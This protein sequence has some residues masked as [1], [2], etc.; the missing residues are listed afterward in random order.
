MTPV[1]GHVA[2]VGAGP[3]DPELITVRGLR[4]LE[5]ADVV[6]VDRLAPRELLARLDP[7]VEIVDAGKRRGCHTL[8]Q[9]AIEAL[10]VERAR[11]GLRV[12]R[13]KGGDPF[14]FGRGGEE[15]L[16]CAAAGIP[17]EVVPGVSSAFAGPARAGIP[18]THRGLAEQVRVMSG[19]GAGGPCGTVD[20]VGVGRGT[21]T[22]VLLMA[23]AGLERISADLIRGGRA[24]GT[25]TAVIASAATPAERILV[26]ELDSVAADVCAAGIEPPAVVV[27]GDVVRLRDRVLGR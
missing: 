15:A 24:P 17:F 23:L 7:H 10:L 5:Q 20:W 13:L 19:H 11:R 9:G 22:L 3:G 6:V 16:A 4:R 25:P 27:V 21:E 12:V 1:P 18:V 26:T 2:L 8:S 14:V